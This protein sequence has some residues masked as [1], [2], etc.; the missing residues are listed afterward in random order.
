MKIYRDGKAIELTE[1][2]LTHLYLEIQRRNCADEVILKLT[3]DY[4]VDIEKV[5]IT[6]I[7]SDVMEEIA[8]NDTIWDCEQETY[9][10][11]I[12]KYLEERGN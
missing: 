9:H 12:K 6:R 2:E 4:D 10:S 1:T 11:V 7:V 3:E 8:D 5:N